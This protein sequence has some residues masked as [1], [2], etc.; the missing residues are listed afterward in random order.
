MF[1]GE[2]KGALTAA[3][4]R[5]EVIPGKARISLGIAD[6]FETFDAVVSARAP[7][8]G[9]TTTGLFWPGRGLR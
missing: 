4:S 8:I 1:V 3:L 7:R 5:I 6:R 9:Q 2:H